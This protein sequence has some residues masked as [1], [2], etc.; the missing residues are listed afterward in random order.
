MT[1]TLLASIFLLLA[2]ACLAQSDSIQNLYF[3]KKNRP[4]VFGAKDF[5]PGEKKAFYIY[6]NGMYALVLKN[7]KQVKAWVKDIK[8]D[9]IYYTEF[10]DTAAL[11]DTFA[12]HPADIKKFNLAGR[13]SVGL[14]TGYSADLFN[15]H[16]ENGATPKTLHYKIDTVYVNDS[17]Q[18]SVYASVPHITA[19][20]IEYLFKQCGKT[21]YY[22]EKTRHDTPKKPYKFVV[23]NFI[24][25]TPSRVNQ[26]NG[27]NLGIQ[28]CKFNDR[29]MII[30]GV[31]INADAAMALFT[32]YTLPYLAI[33]NKL[34]D[35]DDTVGKSR[36]NSRISGLSLSAGG[37]VGEMQVEGLIVNGGICSIIEARGL[38]ITGTQNMTE[39]FGGLVITGLRNMAIDGN[40]VQIGLLNYCKHLKGVQIGLWNVN[41][42]RK[43]P[44]INWS[45]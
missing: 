23:K 45:F 10:S 42:K 33:G 40:G 3:V 1:R 19:Q 27:L 43:L 36:M 29:P 2:T 16:F 24:W 12:L 18:V 8:N 22:P 41:S 15:Y 34:S 20:G 37:L 11:P 6:R 7:K 30:N 14:Y 38:V 4:V 25:V 17:S 13:M 28:T 26:I 32:F 44:F 5:Q 9:S 21:H 31:N 39:E 35:L